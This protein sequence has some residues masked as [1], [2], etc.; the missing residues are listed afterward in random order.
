M[1]RIFII[2]IY[3]WTFFWNDKNSTT[4][5]TTY[6]EF[7]YIFRLDKEIKADEKKNLLPFLENLLEK[8]HTIWNVSIINNI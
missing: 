1:L 8:N 5:L 6:L 3:A 7:N 2:L 4:Y